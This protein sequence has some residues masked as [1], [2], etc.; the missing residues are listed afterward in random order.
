M[1]GSG[2]TTILDH[3]SDQ[4]GQKSDPFRAKDHVDTVRA[5]ILALAAARAGRSFCPSEVA[6]ALCGDG[7]DWRSLMP[8][9][10]N[11]AAALQRDGRLRIMQRGRDID[12]AL[13]KG[14]VRLASRDGQR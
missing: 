7:G 10:R 9:V 4:A 6:R 1:I 13:A 12:A 14:P 11:A 5:A 2:K 3:M 8:D